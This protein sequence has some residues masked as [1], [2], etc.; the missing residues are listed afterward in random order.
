MDLC[1]FSVPSV[2]YDKHELTTLNCVDVLH[3]LAYANEVF[4]IQD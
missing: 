2:E 1:L 3:E 4:G